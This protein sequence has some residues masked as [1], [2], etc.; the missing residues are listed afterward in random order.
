M[1]LAT[2]QDGSR[3][4]QL[5]VVSRDLRHACYATH[6]ATRLQ[7]LLDDWNFIS[8]QLEELYLHLNAGRVAHS[9]VFDPQRCMAPL[10]RAFQWIEADAFR[11]MPA[12]A[13][14]LL[15][16]LAC[17]RLL[18]PH[19]AVELPPATADIDMG[20]GVAA[21][22]GDLPLEA[23][24]ERAL[25]GIRLLL[26][27]NTV[28]LPA[29]ETLSPVLARPATAFSPVA[30]TPDEL[31]TAWHDGRIWQ[32]LQVHC[33]GKRMALCDAGS[34]MQ[35]G[36]HELLAAI[37]RTRPVRAGSIIGCGPLASA[38]GSLGYGSIVARRAQESEVFGQPQTPW[39]AVGDSVRVEMKG[40]DGQSLFGVIEHSYI[41]AGTVGAS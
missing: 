26:L 36:L 11:P 4:G 28:R 22:C 34:A 35:R 7:Q 21:I 12:Q 32:A 20:A 38:D 37:C 25:E 6:A 17:D 3:D 41:R 13:A 10:P 5:V 23:T 2:Y 30:V 33:N 19:E 18:G 39:L 14:P 15:R 16:Q 27:A 40:R 29:L 8:P 1:K 9:F 24:P 31:G